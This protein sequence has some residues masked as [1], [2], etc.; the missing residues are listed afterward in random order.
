MLAVREV[1]AVFLRQSFGKF[2]LKIQTAQVICFC[3]ISQPIIQFCQILRNRPDARKRIG[4]A[5]RQELIVVRCDA[6][7][8]NRINSGILCGNTHLFHIFRRFGPR[9]S[10]AE[11]VESAQ[12]D[13]PVGSFRKNM[14]GKPS[15][16]TACC[17]AADA[18]VDVDARQS[19]HPALSRRDAVTR[20][21]AV[22]QK[23]CCPFHD[24]THPLHERNK[25]C[26]F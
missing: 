14:G 9:T 7:C 21:D 4:P 6:N 16:H 26:Y 25:M 12:N 11:V 20:R 13:H 8:Y 23:Y 15:A 1:A 24:F 3:I 17:V 18:A 22:S 19:V 10:H 5:A 2:P